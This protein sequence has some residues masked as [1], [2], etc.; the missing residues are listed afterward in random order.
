MPAMKRTKPYSPT[1]AAKKLKVSRAAIHEAIK[2]KRL[3]ATYKIKKVRVYEIAPSELDAF[4]VSPR[5]Q[6]AGQEKK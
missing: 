4:E 5:H 1:E 2:T 3:K 6:K